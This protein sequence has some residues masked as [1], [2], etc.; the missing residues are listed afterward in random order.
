MLDRPSPLGHIPGHCVLAVNVSDAYYKEMGVGR[1][2]FSRPEKKTLNI[3]LKFL[4]MK[5]KGNTCNSKEMY[6]PSIVIIRWLTE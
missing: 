4:S 3:I 2:S 6:T 1:F 5:M